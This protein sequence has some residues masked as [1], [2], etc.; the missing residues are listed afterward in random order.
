MNKLND[1]A[2]VLWREDRAVVIGNLYK[3]QEP[4]KTVSITASE[5][6]NEVGDNEKIRSFKTARL[7]MVDEKNEKFVF[8]GHKTPEDGGK[9]STR[10]KY[11]FNLPF[12]Q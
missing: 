4:I 6:I 9:K 7:F 8:I 10:R 3:F 11:I 12:T 5:K 1:S 2:P